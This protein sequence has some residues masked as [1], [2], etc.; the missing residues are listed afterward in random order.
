MKHFVAILALASLVSIQ[1]ADVTKGN[2]GAGK[3]A[4]AQPKTERKSEGK[5]RTATYPFYGTLDST[6]AKQK[7][8]TLRGKKKNRVILVTDDTRI[9]KIGA[10]VTLQD[11]TPGERVSGSVRKNAAGQEEAVTIRFGPKE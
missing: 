9:Q 8:I 11:G 6:D 2:F 10:S 5:A 1:G 7:T 3:D 4:G